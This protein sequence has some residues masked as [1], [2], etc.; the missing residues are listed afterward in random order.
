MS[1]PPSGIDIASIVSIGSEGVSTTLAALLPRIG[2]AGEDTPAN[3]GPKGQ[4]N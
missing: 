3:I 2:I 1:L 4:I